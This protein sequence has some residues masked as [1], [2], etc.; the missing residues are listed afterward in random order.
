MC[1]MARSYSVR[2]RRRPVPASRRAGRVARPLQAG[3]VSG[4]LRACVATAAV[5]LCAALLLLG[6]RAD[7]QQ[8]NAQQV[9]QPPRGPL[10]LTITSVSPSYAEQ[11]GTVTITGRVRN[12]AATPATGLS[13]R[14]WSSKAQLGSRLDLENYAS[15]SYL[16]LLQPVSAVPVTL[17]RLD[18]GHSWSWTISLPVR[19]LGLSCF[20]VYPLTVEASDAAFDVARDPVPLPYWPA[21]AKSCPGQRRPQPFAIS[22]IWPLIAVPHQG[23]CGLIDNGLAKT[24][25]PDGRLGYLLAIGSRY[26]AQA[27]LTWAIDPS[28]LDSVAAMRDSYPVGASANC[29]PGPELPASPAASRWLAGVLKATTGQTVFLTPYADVDVAAL[30]R[31]G[32]QSDLDSAFAAAAQ[33]GHRILHRSAPAPIPAG[34]HQLSAIAWP[35]QGIASGALLALLATKNV[36]TAIL[37]APVSPVNYTPGAV[38][39]KLT[40][41]GKQMHIL[42]ADRAITAL[43]RSKGSASSQPGSI[44]GTSQLYL[45]E[46]AMI[47]SEAPGDQRPIVVAPPRRWDPPSQLASNLLAET[48]SAPWLKP[49]TAGQLATMR[50]ERV[51]PS[52]TQSARDA[53]LS[54]HLLDKVSKLDQQLALLQSIRAQPD[55]ALNRAILGIE[56]S[57]WRGKG[58][59]H[60]QALLARTTRYMNSQ[61]NGISIRGVSN[62]PGTKHVPYHVTFGGKTASVN[63]VIHNALRYK[64]KVGLL[65]QA[66]HV[67]VTGQPHLISIPPESYSGPVTLTVHVQAKHG[68][69][70]LSLISPKG[71]PLPANR[72]VIRVHATNFGTFA[73]AIFAIALALFVIASAFRAIRNGRPAFPSAAPSAAGGWPDDPSSPAARSESARPASPDDA[74]RAALE[75]PGRSGSPDEPARSASAGEPA[76]SASGAERPSSHL[77]GLPLSGG[78]MPDGWPEPAS[79]LPAWPERQRAGSADPDPASSPSAWIVPPGLHDATARDA[80]I[81]QEGFPDLG[82]RPEYTDSVGGDGS[83]LTSA[84]PSVLDEEP[85]AP[86]RRATEEPR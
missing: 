86:S 11:G 45:A 41:I 74:A 27:R 55:P 26:S 68:T 62:R 85:V 32:S 4:P 81:A 57:A 75:D 48:V 64:V 21:N 17:A 13:V 51:Y 35:A 66:E 65:V 37:A 14:L 69:I 76:R 59:K 82:N 15:G 70:R 34:P 73:L 60:A 72:L 30:T 40:R 2:Q 38:A 23:V 78:P 6:G 63:V 56:S 33:V 50:P 19:E 43:L 28:L 3:R 12:L 29:R 42:L 7:A 84:G 31:H 10:A 71:S 1:A 36:S 20:G 8:S 67:T 22:W 52:F 79:E 54:G 16:P 9:T 83:E 77:A 39:S 46:T 47:A 49:S 44:F 61:L 18:A 24:I 5:A 80:A 53:E 58:G 25:T